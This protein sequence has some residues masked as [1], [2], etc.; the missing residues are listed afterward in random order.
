MQAYLDIENRTDFLKRQMKALKEKTESDRYRIHQDQQNI[1]KLLFIE[2]MVEFE[3]FWSERKENPDDEFFAKA[4]R[5]SEDYK[6]QLMHL[7]K[8]EYLPED[9]GGYF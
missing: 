1:R 2:N 9:E 6:K 4:C 3:T 8:N 7:C 5:L